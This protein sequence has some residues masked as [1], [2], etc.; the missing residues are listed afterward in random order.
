M[1][2]ELLW[3]K[4]PAR[5]KLVKVKTWQHMKVIYDLGSNRGDNIP[6]YLL[7]A[8]KVVAVEANPTLCSLISE[9]FADEVLAR[10]VV[11][12][13]CVLTENNDSEFV[14]F[15]LHRT[16]SVLSQLPMPLEGNLQSFEQ[17]SLPAVSAPTLIG[18]HGSPWFIKIDI[19]HFD[20]VVLRTLFNAGIYPDYLSAEAH[21]VDVFALMVAEGGY[22]SFK[23]VDGATVADLYHAC[24]IRDEHSQL[25]VRHTFPFHSAGPFGNDIPGKW[26][27]Q[28]NFFRRLA[29]ESLGWKDI[30][31]SR[32]DEADPAAEAS[33][34][35]LILREATSSSLLAACAALEPSQQLQIVSAL[36]RLLVKGK[37]HNLIWKLRSP[38]R[39]LTFD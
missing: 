30:H 21:C 7:K 18:R 16:N 33:V 35:D 3:P 10:R 15:Y 6:Y 38:L 23:L 4:Q 28:T 27:T 31:A 13:N 32:V 12:E 22:S 29:F 20:H 19:E 24:L 26:M 34:H 25:T 11:V 2:V 1:P 36:S 14:D 37:L 5:V 17:V 39:R 8:D 9:R